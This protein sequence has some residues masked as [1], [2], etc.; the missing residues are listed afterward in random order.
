[1]LNIFLGLITN[2]LPLI[3]IRVSLST[4]SVLVNAA[5]RIFPRIKIFRGFSLHII[6]FDGRQ[7][8]RE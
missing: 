7:L 4:L 1:M 3:Y 5:L 2:S 8:N 6:H